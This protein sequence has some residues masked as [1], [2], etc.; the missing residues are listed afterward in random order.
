MLFFETY[1]PTLSDLE[2]D[3]ET[4]EKEHCEY[5]KKLIEQLNREQEKGIGVHFEAVGDLLRGVMGG[6]KNG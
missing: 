6:V 2:R 1:L 5:E 4:L 3:M